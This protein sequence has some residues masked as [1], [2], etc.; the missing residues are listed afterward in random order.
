MSTQNVDVSINAF[1][2]DWQHRKKKKKEKHTRT[3]STTTTN[4][5][6]DSLSNKANLSRLSTLY[7]WF[8]TAAQKA[9]QIF[10]HFLFTHTQNDS[11]KK[12]RWILWRFI[13]CLKWIRIDL[14]FDGLTIHL[15]KL[16]LNN[17]NCWAHIA[18]SHS[19]KIDEFLI[20]FY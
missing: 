8:H 20:F 3:R 11:E 6:D 16:M 14:T 1:R 9:Q 15:H 5:Y 4:E 7:G 19:D 10:P 12:N 18:C 17:M 13:S 2:S